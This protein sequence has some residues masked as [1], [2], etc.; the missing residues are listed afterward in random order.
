MA[1][2]MSASTLAMPSKV[3]RDGAA[4]QA[5]SQPKAHRPLF[6]LAAADWY[7]LRFGMDYIAYR[8]LETGERSVVSHVVG[9]DKVAQQKKKR[10][11]EKKK[12]K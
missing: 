1:L 9:L 7:C 11:K 3:G 10:K 12:E 2:T 6:H 4:E 5:R 8:G